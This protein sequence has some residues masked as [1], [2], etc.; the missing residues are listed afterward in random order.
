VRIGPLDPIMPESL[1]HRWGFSDRIASRERHRFLKGT[2]TQDRDNRCRTSHFAS[3]ASATWPAAV[4][5]CVTS[6]AVRQLSGTAPGPIADSVSFNFEE[7]I[8]GELVREEG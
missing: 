6:F 4:W 1:S 7:A 8:D 2:R 5:T 3:V